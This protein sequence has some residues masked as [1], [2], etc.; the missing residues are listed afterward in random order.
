MALADRGL[1]VEAPDVLHEIASHAFELA[2]S[3]KVRLPITAEFPL[4]EAADAH[5]LMAGRSSTGKLVI[6]VNPE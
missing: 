1:S 6:A 4:A 3:G 2:T 5:R